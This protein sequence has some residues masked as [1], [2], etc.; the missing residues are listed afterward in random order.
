MPA[1]R[2]GDWEVEGDQAREEEIE[3]M[4]MELVL[5]GIRGGSIETTISAVSDIVSAVMSQR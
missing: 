5:E 3:T 2:E 1:Q 4:G